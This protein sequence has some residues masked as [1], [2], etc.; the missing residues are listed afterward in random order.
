VIRG[1]YLVCER[2]SWR[3][4]FPNCVGGTQRNKEGNRERMEINK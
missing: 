3:A 2:E 1:S 4:Q